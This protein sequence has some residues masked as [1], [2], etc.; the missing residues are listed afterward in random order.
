MQIAWQTPQSASHLAPAAAKALGTALSTYAAT[1]TKRARMRLRMKLHRPPA[2]N[3]SGF[4]V[5]EV[6]LI[7][8]IVVGLA[9]TGF[10]V[11]QRHKSTSAK[12][13][14]A[15]SP[16]QTTAYSHSTVAQSAPARLYEGSKRYT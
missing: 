2:R 11:Y 12:N 13:S 15:T 7:V 4:S 3:Q 9:V 10:V 5:V 14:A 1:G 8:L 6:L 16:N